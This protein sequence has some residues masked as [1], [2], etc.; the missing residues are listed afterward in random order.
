M[1]IEF[2]KFEDLDLAVDSFSA[3]LGIKKA[4]GS[5]LRK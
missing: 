1:T 2:G 3:R 5:E 4:D